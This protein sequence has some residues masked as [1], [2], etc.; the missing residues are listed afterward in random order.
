MRIVIFDPSQVIRVTC[1][2]PLQK[3]GHETIVCATIQ[4]A[5]ATLETLD[6]VPELVLLGL[7]GACPE[8]R[9]LVE[10]LTISPRYARCESILVLSSEPTKRRPSGL[11]SCEHFLRPFR[12]QDLLATIEAYAASGQLP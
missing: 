3:A 12:V 6:P 5:W 9:R 10:R 1:L 7:M 4:Q 2:V 8:A 11:K